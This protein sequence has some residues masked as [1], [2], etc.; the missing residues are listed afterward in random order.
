MVA[1]KAYRLHTQ[2]AY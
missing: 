2:V 1:L